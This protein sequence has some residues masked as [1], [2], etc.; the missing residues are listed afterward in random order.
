MY[1]HLGFAM[2]KELLACDQVWLNVQPATAQCGYGLLPLHALGVKGGRIHA[3]IPMA[4]L[5]GPFPSDWRDMGGRLTTPGLVD[6]HTHL[7]YAGSR[8]TEFEQRLHG[9]PY[10]E[11]ARQGGGILSTVK[12]TREASEDELFALALPRLRALL[13][14]GVTTVEIK[15]GYGL[16][17]ASELKMLRVARRLGK[18]L[19]V[20]VR[21]TLL[22]AHAVP[23]EY[24]GDA[25]GWVE[26]IC[27][28]LIPQVAAE[29]LADAVDVFCEGIAFNLAQ[30]ERIFAA[31]RAHGLPVKGHM[32]QLSSL[33][34]SELAARYQAL[35]VDHL[36]HLDAAGIAALAQA[37][38][39]AVLLP[40]AFYFLRETVLPPV[41]AL[42]DAG[43]AI[44]VA[45]DINPGTSPLVSLRLAMNMACT[46]FRLTPQEAFLG[47]TRHG[48]QALGL[49]ET[50]GQLAVGMVAD[51][52]IWECHH[53][54]ELAY[55]VGVDQLV[56]RVVDG[57]DTLGGLA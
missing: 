50:C 53:P 51:F 10:S 29:Q 12:A 14:E 17:C 43:V 31:A 56:A 40:G 42:R 5:T 6:C 52:L 1:I 37:G 15:S 16:T 20:R 57:R 11:I 32:E 18:A 48:A 22:A 35:S 55:Q 7:I 2:N 34:G 39:V 21:T 24:T 41:Q 45:S 30:C 13:R 33:G 8:A 54:A 47:V 26:V 46:L 36:E 4:Q 28:D 19:P 9:V 27:R 49:G 25:D 3:L 38:T 44:A 23:P